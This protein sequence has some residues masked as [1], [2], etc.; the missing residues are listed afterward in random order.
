MPCILIPEF[1][2]GEALSVL[3]AAHDVDFAP[4]LARRPDELAQRIAH[5]E[6]LIV[7]NVTQVRGT[8]LAAAGRLRVVGR[9]GVGL[10]N[11]D[12]DA[13][14]DRNIKVIPA[15]GANAASVAE[16]V[17]TSAMILLRG[18]YLANDAVLAGEWPRTKLIGH[19]IA[20][21]T[22]GLVG[23]GSIARQTARR[24][25]GLDLAVIAHDPMVP[26]DD[27]AWSAM[28][29]R[30]VALDALL[31]EADIVSLHVPLLE[32]TRNIIDTAALAAMKP[33]AILVNSAR[34]GLVDE[35]A[36]ATALRGGA[37]AGAALDVFDE[38][39]F[40]AGSH[41][42]DVPN[43]L[44]TPHIAGVTVE[45]NARVSMM[46]ARAVTDFLE[47]QRS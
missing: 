30:R 10:D 1:I 24:A 36:L 15:T 9:L 13:C 42:L 40:P 23:F 41:F 29:V 16:W 12:L 39:P 19:E 27:P 7:R 3:E 4:D 33:S 18:A 28:N 34:G 44:L 45:A 31:A 8:L 46:I 37:I 11:I 22:I 21:R 25:Q 6:A 47:G 2:D 20:G 17:L 26:A 5:V 35:P 43:L 14:A 38:E 32:T